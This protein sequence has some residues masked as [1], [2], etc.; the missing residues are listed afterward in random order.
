M[1]KQETNTLT[2]TEYPFDYEIPEF[3]PGVIVKEKE[4]TSEEMTE[5]FG[6]ICNKEHWKGEINAMIPSKD[7]YKYNEAVC[8]FT[9]GGIEQ[10]SN[11][12]DENGLIEVHG[13]GYWIHIGA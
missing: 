2:K 10:E 8:H 4:L 9:G 7:F 12:E 11:G 6:K 13:Y 1:K 3:N 5:L